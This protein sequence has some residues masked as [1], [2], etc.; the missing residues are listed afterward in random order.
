MKSPVIKERRS[1]IETNYVL[2]ELTTIVKGG[3]GGGAKSKSIVASSEIVPIH[4]VPRLQKLFYAQL[5]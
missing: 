2:Y 4:Q 1:L 3:G 5:S